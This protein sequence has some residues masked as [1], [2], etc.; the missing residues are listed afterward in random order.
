MIAVL[1]PSLPLSLGGGA[2]PGSPGP[3]VRK[4]PRCGQWGV[5][6]GAPVLPHPVSTVPPSPS[7][8]ASGGGKLSG[9]ARS[10]AENGRCARSPRPPPPS[11]APG[12]ALERLQPRARPTHAPTRRLRVR[13]RV[14]VRKLGP[15]TGPLPPP[16]PRP[17]L[18][19]R[20]IPARV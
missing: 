7:P 18:L 15:G 2:G 20:G 12:T 10:L 13:V 9:G 17:C 6:G 1:P 5:R 14:P 4:G 8:P 3:R 16:P 11:A 19:R